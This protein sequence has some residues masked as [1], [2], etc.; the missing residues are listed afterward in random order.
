MRPVAAISFATLIAVCLHGY[1]FGKS[2]HTVYLIDALRHESPQLLSTDWFATQTLQYHAAF[3]W[4]TRGLLHL[5]VIEPA[6]LIGYLA[7]AVL[8]HW[9]WWR[10]VKHLS[11]DV[12][13]YLASVVLF[14]ITGGTGLGM[15]QLLQDGAFLPSNVAAVAMLWGICFWLEDRGIAA[16][17]CFGIAGIF[18][19]NF[20][21][22]GIMVWIALRLWG[23]RGRSWLMADALAVIPSLALIVL[24]IARI[25]TNAPPL[26]LAE[27][28]DLYVRLRHPHHYDPS[29][30]PMALWI[31]FLAPIVFGV[32][33]CGGRAGFVFLIF[34][35]LVLVAL[36]FAGATYISEPLIQASLYR[37]SIY[38][39]LLGCVAAGFVLRVP[40]RWTA[41][42]GVAMVVL[43]VLRGPYFG[44]FKIPEDDAGYLAACDWIRQNTPID[45]IFLVPPDE[46]AFRLRAQRAIVVNFKAVPQLS[47]E[48]PAWRDR[49]R[50]VLDLP[51]L[52]TLPRPFETTLHAIRQQYESLPPEHL[53]SIA[54][55]YGARY[56]LTAH[57]IDDWS[58]RRIDLPANSGYFLY[59]LAQ[60]G[61]RP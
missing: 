10:I 4:L 27:F 3:G 38:P 23:G 46:Q 13:I 52:M 25:R 22:A 61:G 18:H 17:A 51:D 55:K 1:Q 37:F 6:F 54:R 33:A 47:G 36:I 2:N 56:V 50:D 19:L 42:V 32:I 40:A 11:G 59:A 31:G 41:I 49:L 24:T 21:L 39:K 9:A 45:A 60:P 8:L 5:H 12:A 43:C 58:M 16:G 29:A 26:P 53:Q 28:V 34:S 7:L 48:L 44:L 14:Y 57:R 15:Y 20:A 30:W 35:T